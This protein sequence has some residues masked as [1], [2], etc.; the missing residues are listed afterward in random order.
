MSASL[1]MACACGRSVTVSCPRLEDIPQAQQQ[2]MGWGFDARGLARCPHCLTAPPGAD[3]K[4][5]ST[6]KE[7]ANG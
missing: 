2:M 7:S 5:S 1:S 6:G 4:T 3:A